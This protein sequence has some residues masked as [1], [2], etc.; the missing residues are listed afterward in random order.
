M[1]ANSIC[2]MLNQHQTTYL[3]MGYLF[4]LR[5]LIISVYQN[6]PLSKFIYYFLLL[7]APASDFSSA[8]SD[9]I[10]INTF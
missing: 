4:H 3:T 6:R 1:A 10:L 7:C 2:K 5:Q 8:T 9:H